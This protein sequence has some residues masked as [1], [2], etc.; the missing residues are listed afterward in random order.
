[1]QHSTTKVTFASPFSKPLQGVY[2]GEPVRITH[3]GD[4]EGQSPVYLVIDQTGRS[5]WKKQE[6]VQITDTDF[7]P[8]SLESLKGISQSMRQ[9][10]GSSTR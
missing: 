4:A 1:M 5:S 3:V 6:E 8:T 9:P 7:L 2:D 10:A